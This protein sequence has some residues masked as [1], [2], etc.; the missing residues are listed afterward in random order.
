MEYSLTLSAILARIEVLDGQISNDTAEREDLHVAK[1][2]Y[3][4][5]VGPNGAGAIQNAA[6]GI[7]IEAP[8]PPSPSIIPTPNASNKPMNL[9]ALVKSVMTQAISLWMTS[10]EIRKL[11]SELK[12]VEVSSGSIAPTLW[13]LKND[14]AIV[15]KGYKVALA[16]RLK[17]NEPLNGNPASGSEAGTDANPFPNPIN[18]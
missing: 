14:G 3:L 16:S 10:E 7:A 4:R 2:V 17:E 12:G 11:V 5:M 6:S 1:R 15:R 9:S 13:T 18:S 8:P